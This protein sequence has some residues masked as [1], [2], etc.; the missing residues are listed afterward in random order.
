M[1]KLNCDMGESFGAW[2]MGLD[3]EIMPLVDMSNIACGFHASDPVTMDK[4]VKLAYEN[5]VTIGAHPGYPDLVGF[6]RRNLKCSNDEIKKM[7]IYQIGAL[8][9]ICKTNNAKITYVKP[10]GALYN[11]MMSDSEVFEAIA[12]AIATYDK[13]L[14]LMILSSSKNKQYTKI[15][16]NLGIK[17][18]FEVFADRS[19]MDDG[20]LMP[21]SMPNAVLGSSDEVLERLDFLIKEGAIKAH[22]GK[23]LELKVD[24]IC[25]HGDNSHALS[26]VKAMRKYLDKI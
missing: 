20:S 12:K 6:G 1:I 25:V 11:T 13:K 8:E 18:L 4:T 21:R 14:N 10:H 17:L 19:Y 3:E 24:C 22:T 7:I 2:K 15:A 26:I 5:G 9:A 23:K 16:E